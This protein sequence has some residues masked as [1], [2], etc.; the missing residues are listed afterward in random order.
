MAPLF[1]RHRGQ[2]DLGGL[3]LSLARLMTC[4]YLSTSIELQD[5]LA[6]GIGCQSRLVNLG[7]VLANCGN[8]LPWLERTAKTPEVDGILGIDDHP[9]TSARKG[10]GPKDGA[11]GFRLDRDCSI[12]RHGYGYAPISR[13]SNR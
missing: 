7:H 4:P 5:K 9:E 10:V 3:C 1:E 2:L 6:I 13:R 8:K 11:L 12:E